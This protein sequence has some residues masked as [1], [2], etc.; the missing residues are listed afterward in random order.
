MKIGVND[1]GW[2][3]NIQNKFAMTIISLY[4]CFLY[5]KKLS[6]SVWTDWVN[7]TVEYVIFYWYDDYMQWI[8]RIERSND[9][10]H[11]HNKHMWVMERK[12]RMTIQRSA[13]V[14]EFILPVSESMSSGTDGLASW[15]ILLYMTHNR[16]PVWSSCPI[17][18]HTTKGV[19][20]YNVEKLE[21]ISCSFRN[22]PNVSR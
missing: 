14:V 17:T 11:H 10:C 2:R 21:S 1:E 20:V 13:L 15:L 9:H 3:K 7:V 5:K 18:T 19:Q 6:T 16:F 4:S 12:S 8:G 22:W